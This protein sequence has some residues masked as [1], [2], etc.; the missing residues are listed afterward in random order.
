MYGQP[1]T[2]YSEQA[3]TLDIYR[4]PLSLGYVRPECSS[5]RSC[6]T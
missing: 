3:S 4:Q 2:L 6:C 5:Y 1:R